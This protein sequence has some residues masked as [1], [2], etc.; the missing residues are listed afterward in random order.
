MQESLRTITESIVKFKELFFYIHHN[1][2]SEYVSN[3]NEDESALDSIFDIYQ[4]TKSKLRGILDKWIL[5]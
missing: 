4:S 3:I 2:V 1:Q 5:K